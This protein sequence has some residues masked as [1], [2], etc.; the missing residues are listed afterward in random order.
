[1]NRRSRIPSFSAALLFLVLSRPAHAEENRFDMGKRL[2]TLSRS[3]K[4]QI[5]EEYAA[6]IQ[7]TVSDL[8][9]VWSVTIRP[10]RNISVRKGS[11]EEAECF[12]TADRETYEKIFKGEFT[13]L[14]A[15]GR[16]RLSD[17]APLD[18]HLAPGLN[19]HEERKR[20]YPFILHFF[21]SS[22]PEKILLGEKHARLVH[23]AHAIPLYY[24]EG[25][26]SAWYLIKPGE[27]L[28]EPGDTNPFPQ[29]FIF[30]G[31]EGYAKIGPDTVQVRAGESFF[32]PP[33]SD[34]VVWTE[35]E[36]PLILI[37]LAWG[38]GA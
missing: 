17:P 22:R 25:F 37:F 8:N 4:H 35:G 24:H 2:E 20:L 13:A 6:N 38:D 36:D 12:F 7:F 1:M 9:E 32:I 28:N 14:T 10:G 29:A 18:F 26:R 27:R 31:G 23:G 21:N 5:D 16:A 30:I 11:N 34:H 3:F 15:A 33:G 19:F